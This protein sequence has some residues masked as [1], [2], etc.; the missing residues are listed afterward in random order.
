MGAASPFSSSSLCCPSPLFSSS[1]SPSSFS[2]SSAPSLPR[3]PSPCFP[4]P[5]PALSPLDSPPLGPFYLPLPPPTFFFTRY[6][7]AYLRLVNHLP[8]PLL[9]ILPVVDVS[10]CEELRNRI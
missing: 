8:L 3:S 2:F 1:A 4:T 7:S 9:L 6:Y 10:M 5:H